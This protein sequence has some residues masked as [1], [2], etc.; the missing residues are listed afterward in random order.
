MVEAMRPGVRASSSGPSGEPAKG[1]TVVVIDDEPQM[2]RFLRAALVSLGYR[3][4][5]A[6]TGQD[7]LAEAATR[8]PDVIILDLGLPDLD[9]LEII[10]R[11]R[12]WSTVPIIVLSARD[13]E[14]DMIKALDLA[15]AA[16]AEATLPALIEE[17]QTTTVVPASFTLYVDGAGYLV[18]ASRDE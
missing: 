1:P 14:G 2:R 17:G 4:H 12:E 9:G 8:Q 11:V 3:F 18:M 5:E 13:Q 6:A 16:D 15:M 10:R 7:G